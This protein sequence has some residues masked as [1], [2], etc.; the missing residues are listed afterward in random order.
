MKIIL[1]LYAF[2]YRIIV[3][4][5]LTVAESPDCSECPPEYRRRTSEVIVHE[6]YDHLNPTSAYDIALIRVAKAM[7]L[8]D[9]DKSAVVPVCLPWDTGN[10]VETLVEDDKLTVTGW[11]KITNHVRYN[12]RQLKRFKVAQ[13][14]LQILKVRDDLL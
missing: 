1:H 14:K 2:V 4:G 5:E 10:A 3:L 6:K 8:F 7:T 12:I 9:D 11:G 13:R